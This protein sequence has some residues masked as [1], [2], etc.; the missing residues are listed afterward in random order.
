MRNHSLD[1]REC[2]APSTILKP[3]ETNCGIIYQYI[4]VGAPE[5]MKCCEISVNLTELLKR[6]IYLETLIT[7]T[8]VFTPTGHD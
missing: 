8:P 2:L 6:G 4:H 7:R 1:S 3:C 5:G